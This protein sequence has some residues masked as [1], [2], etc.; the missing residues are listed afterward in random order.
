AHGV[1]EKV[2]AKARR[3][4]AHLLEADPAD[5][6]LAD[7]RATIRGTDVSVTWEEIV[8]VA[9][10]GKVPEGE[11][12]GMDAGHVFESG[13]LNFPFGAHLAV[14]EVDGETGAVRLEQMWAVD[15][16]GRIVN[17]MLAAG[18]R[19]GG[20]AQG[21]GQALWEEIRYDQDGNLVTATLMDYLLPAPGQLPSFRLEE[22]CT[23]TPTN[24]LGAK[25]IGE[26]G[27]IGSTPA[28]VNAV[29][30]AL[31]LDELQIPLRPE[32]LWQAIKGG[33][34]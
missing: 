23:P 13:G 19:H 18:Q 9:F 15:D 10:E 3:I 5:V 1:A 24:P 8:A 29:A 7:G 25:G 11:E 14:V 22:T 21:I 26:A 34:T 2:A 4:G 6:E 17:P 12:R 27:T 33:T 31:G 28:V 32:Q 16:A 30:D 20:L